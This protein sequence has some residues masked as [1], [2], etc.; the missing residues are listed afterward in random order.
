[1]KILAFALFALALVGCGQ[2]TFNAVT[3]APPGAVAEFHQDQDDRWIDVTEG[4]AFGV[5]CEDDRHDACSYDGTFV[6]DAAIANVYRGY[7][8]LSKPD[9]YY[10][11]P[12][13][14]TSKTVIVVVG[15]AVGTTLMRVRTGRGDYN[16]RINVKPAP[17]RA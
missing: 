4:V 15:L 13:S 11:D 8:D 5:S 3:A 9:D 17:P 6:A 7:S 16:V 10:T 12:N 14:R 1:M 2:P